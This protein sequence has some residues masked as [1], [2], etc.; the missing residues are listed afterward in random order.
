MRRFFLIAACTAFL[1]N[2]AML[3]GQ[4]GAS[5]VGTAVK[6]EMV[7]ENLKDS[8]LQKEVIDSPDVAARKEAAYSG[9]HHIKR[10]YIFGAAGLVV[11]VVF[12]V[13]AGK[14]RKTLR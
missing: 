4:M 9:D 10:R 14:R 5:Q 7:N 1:A 11:L 12:A 13:A 6:A 8:G 2:P 3:Q